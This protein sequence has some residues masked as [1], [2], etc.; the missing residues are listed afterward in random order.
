MSLLC[1]DVWLVGLKY[2][3]NAENSIQHLVYLFPQ[4]AIEIGGRSNTK[5]PLYYLPIFMDHILP[6]DVTRVILMDADFFFYSDIKLL[7]D[8]FDNFK[9]T[10][11]FGLA[12]VQL[13][14]YRGAFKNYRKNHPGTK[15]GDPPP[16]ASRDTMEVFACFT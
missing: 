12:Y 2:R 8:H 5:M 10:T 9:N 13:P 7:F 16:M 11:I 6:E 3:I 4:D 1:S 15:I 14:T